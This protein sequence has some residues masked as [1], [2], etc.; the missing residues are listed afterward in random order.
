[1]TELNMTLSTA[2]DEL[3]NAKSEKG[4]ETPIKG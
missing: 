1:M 4:V 2:E 3:N